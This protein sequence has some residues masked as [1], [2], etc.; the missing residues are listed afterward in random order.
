MTNEPNPY[1]SPAL[2]NEA[3]SSAY[4]RKREVIIAPYLSPRLHANFTVTFLVLS[5]LANLG[6][7]AGLMFT[8]ALLQQISTGYQPTPADIAADSMR[9]GISSFALIIVRVIAVVAFMF[10]TYRVARNLPA[11]GTPDPDYSPGWAVGFYFIPILNLFRPYQATLEIWIGSSPKPRDWKEQS[12]VSVPLLSVWWGVWLFS[13]FIGRVLE[14]MGR[15]EQSADELLTHNYLVIAVV[16]LLEIPR[17][18]L[19]IWVVRAISSAQEERHQR[20]DASPPIPQE[21]ANPFAFDA[22]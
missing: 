20:M 2:L 4:D 7:V 1:A 12:Q 22:R 10:W 16:L 8:Q 14:R 21:T 19:S 13:A 5:I 17:D 11:L 15:G 18:L 6:L 3:S 9:L